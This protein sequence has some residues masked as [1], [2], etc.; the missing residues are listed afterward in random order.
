MTY[1]GAREATTERPII[2]RLPRIAG[3]LRQRSIPLRIAAISGLLLSALIATNVIVIRELD[4]GSR[5][6]TDA[7]E[8][9]EHLETANAAN[10]AFGQVRYWLTDLAVSLLTLS[11]RNATTARATLGENLD[12]LS[13]YDPEIAEEI[14]RETDAY[15][16]KALEAVEAYTDDR[17]VIGN[18]LLA[19]AREHSAIVEQRLAQLTDDLRRDAWGA[20][21][22][23]L[24]NA[25]SAMH[26]SMAIV[27]AVAVLGIGLTLLVFRSI[28]LPLRRI[29]KAMVAMINGQYEVGIPRAGSDE[30]GTMAQ[31]LGLFRESVAER[32][33]LEE[34]NKRQSRMVQTAIETI[35]EGFAVFDSDDRLVLANSK[36][37][38]M[39]PGV[40]KTG[41][42]FEEIIEAAV[43]RGLVEFHG[44]PAA[45][46]I[47]ERLERHRR[48]EGFFEQEYAD[49]RWVRVSERRTP[50]DGI[51][52]V[53]AD[54]SE[55][56][57]RQAELE[58]ARER[59][60]SASRAK[61]QFV[62]NMSHEL[63]TP[64]NAVIG[65]SEML[66]EEAEDLGSQAFVPDL[67]KIR[68]A[69]K[70]LLGLINDIL[71]FSKIEAGKMDVLVEE[72]SVEHLLTQVE[73]TIAPLMARNGNTMTVIAGPNLGSMRS[74]ET[75][76][77]QILFNLLSNAAKFTERGTVTLAARAINGEDGADRL[78][79]R[80]SDTG[81]GM[82][83]EQ[84]ERL[85]QAFVQAEPSTTR[86][87]GGTGLG[88][89][90]TK[91]FSIMLGGEIEVET[92]FGS[93]ST[94][95]VRL[96]RNFPEAP[97][98]E[99]RSRTEGSAH[100]TVLVVDDEPAA[101]NVLAAAL[102]SA[103]YRV[104]TAAGGKEGLRL[105]RQDRPDA[106]VLDVIMPDLDGWAV[107]R[108]LKSEPDL[109]D[110]PVVLAT[111][112][113]D[114]EMGL[115]LGAAEHLTKPIDPAQLLPVVR[116]A[117]RSDGPTDVLV[118]DD[119]PGTREVLR[120]VLS[121]EGWVVREAENGAAGLDEIARHRPAVVLLDLMMPR[122]DGFET[123]RALRQNDMT[124]ELP[125]VIITS[126]DLDRHE[127]DWLH[128]NALSVFQKGAYE[129]TRL[130]ETL[131]RM[132]EAARNK[133]GETTR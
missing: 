115:A 119:D 114:R 53:F 6:I 18:T 44:V 96:P 87:Y 31:T 58:H 132:V 14:A 71:D 129:R 4:E 100:G 52:G 17:R 24:A 97:P 63:R 111:I 37:G 113:G 84:K 117:I 21:D 22:Q 76:I 33:R 80:V 35:S 106:I 45:D 2:P 121:R 105:A 110:I 12:R 7:T 9:F 108:S 8:L 5:R 81:I 82:T 20:R 1:A 30:I 126:K 86:T 51:V 93:G 43:E 59:A 54:I 42:R 128:A 116:R 66:I 83:P 55:L 50:D 68:D 102:A 41:W 124:P 57:R 104:L 60:D 90:I 107:L 28:V 69:G 47:A 48:A 40:A 15:M 77:R 125:V 118:V 88:L 16:Q 13:S 85:F 122:M 3:Y 23:A 74:D 26:T 39:F 92:E 27:A 91:Q 133:T 127:R 62:A 101:R 130:V 61:S 123:L 29:N 73:A 46:W 109:C 36:Y 103:G 75:K 11:E 79:F 49:G 64:L 131:R 67:Q 78:E 34:E 32:A 112:L 72:F 120:R 25:R 95:T 65:Y 19:E 99:P 38:D 89:T 70:H 98:E 94:F 56:K 10:T